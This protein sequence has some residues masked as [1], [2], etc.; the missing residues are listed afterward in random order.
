VLAAGLLFFGAA[1]LHDIAAGTGAESDGYVAE[2]TFDGIVDVLAAALFV[3]GGVGLTNRSGTGRLLLSSA[4][5]V[6]L[7]ETLYWLVRWTSRTG[8]AVVGYA[9]LFAALTV[10]SIACA[11]SRPVSR[12][13]SRS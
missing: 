13:L 6:V 10:A 2:F 1:F 9:L 4:A 5:A 12:W 7:V 3:A 8:T 11:W